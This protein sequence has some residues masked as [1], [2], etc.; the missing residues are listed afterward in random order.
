VTGRRDS[1]PSSYHH[2]DLRSALL[3]ATIELVRE[4]GLE[5]VTMRAVANR[6]GVS[7]AAPYHHFANKAELLA[8]AAVLAFSA[9]GDAIEHGIRTSRH[10]G[11][12]PVLGAATGYVTFG[13]DR[14]GE[15]QLIFGRHIAEL[16]LDAR[17][18]VRAAGGAS[19]TATID[20]LAES[21]T[22]RGSRATATDTFPLVRAV[23]HGIVDLVRDQEL[24]SHVT[25]SDAIDMAT[26]AVDALL[27]G[28]ATDS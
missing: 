9:F 4:V 1:T 10:E 2:G 5:A 19:I 28:L 18:E 7:E 22:R 14:P 15:Y 16:G 20:A 8:G 26:R 17:A 24:G 6:A 12:D 3:D 25:T 27:E 13:L 23:V 11:Q 21:L